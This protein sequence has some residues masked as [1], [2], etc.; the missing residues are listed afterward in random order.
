MTCRKKRIKCNLNNFNANKTKTKNV[1]A[2]K[3][4]FDIN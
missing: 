4:F 2:L 3:A 1:K